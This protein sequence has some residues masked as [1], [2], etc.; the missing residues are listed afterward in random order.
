VPSHTM[1]E[2][3]PTA[4]LHT[5]KKARRILIS[6]DSGSSAR[7]FSSVAIASGSLPSTASR[8]ADSVQNKLRRLVESYGLIQVCLRPGNIEPVDTARRKPRAE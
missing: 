1:A 8:M 3:E 5:K 2:P 4:D 6:A 7:A